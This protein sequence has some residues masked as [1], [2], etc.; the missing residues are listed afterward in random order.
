MK[1]K[2]IVF[3][4]LFSILLIPFTA[5][6]D[7]YPSMLTTSIKVPFSDKLPIRPE[8]HIKGAKFTFTVFPDD[9]YFKDAP[10]GTQQTLKV[11]VGV[12]YRSFMYY[13]VNLDGGKYSRFSIPLNFQISYD[14]GTPQG[15]WMKKDSKGFWRLYGSGTPE[16]VSFDTTGEYCIGYDKT[17]PDVKLFLSPVKNQYKI[18]PD[19]DVVGTITDNGV[20]I[21]PDSVLFMLNGSR[22]NG[23]TFDKDTGIF[24]LNLPASLKPGKYILQITASDTLGNK[25]V[26]SYDL[27]YN[28]PVSAPS[29]KHLSYKNKV[30]TIEWT[31]AKEGTAPIAEY[32]ILRKGPRDKSFIVIGITKPN[33]LYF[34]D[35]VQYNGTYYYEV[36]VQDMAGFTAVSKVKTITV[37]DSSNKD[38][39]VKYKYTI[40]MHPGDPYMIVNGK[41]E[42]I[43]PGRGTKP[44][45]IPKWSRTVVPIRTV[46]ETLGGSAVWFPKERKV[47]ISFNGNLIFLWIGKP[48]AEVNGVMKWID[49]KNH[50]VKPI[51]VNDRTM[52]P[53]RFVAESLGCKVLW[54][55][56]TRTITILY[57]KETGG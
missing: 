26:K 19:M 49:P 28:L 31:K 5:Y 13:F 56:K 45:I 9:F 17:P 21:D 4:L 8:I 43:D 52:L 53:L 2:V 33:V 27:V 55:G 46:V 16:S 32:D 18:Y 20:G 3:L 51:I 37:K 35:K 40:V 48:Q 41:K 12:G 44:V 39:T 57:G 11:T 14:G 15:V 1:R 7:D 34:K 54:D 42:E 50:D 30:V 22:Y 24:S 25:T 23:Y 6:A 38:V 36:Q 47:A 29:I 10:K